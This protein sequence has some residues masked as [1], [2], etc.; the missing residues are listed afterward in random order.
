MIPNEFDNRSVSFTTDFPSANFLQEYG[1]RRAL[2]IRDYGQA[3]QPDLA[4]TLLKWQEGGIVLYSKALFESADPM[5][6]TVSKPSHFGRAWNRVLL[7]L[8]LY[9]GKLGGFGGIVPEQSSG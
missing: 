8:G 6:L 5:P 7:A 4:H 2:L 1:I 3:P 9:R